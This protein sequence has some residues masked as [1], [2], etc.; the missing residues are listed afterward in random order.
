MA[1]EYPIVRSSANPRTSACGK[2]SF[3][4]RAEANKVRPLVTT[5][6]M[7]TRCDARGIWIGATAIVSK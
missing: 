1:G 7:S 4:L 2:I 3:N 5:S 6:S